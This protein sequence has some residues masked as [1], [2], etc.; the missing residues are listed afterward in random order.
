MSEVK[1]EVK[2]ENAIDRGMVT[3]GLLTEDKVRSFN[4]RV[5]ADTG[6]AMLVLPQDQVEALG[7]TEVRKAVVRY[8]DERKEER[9]V[10]GPLIVRVDGRAATVDCIVGPPN[11]EPLLGHIVMEIMDLI[12]DPLQQ[13]LTPRPESPFLP[14]LKLK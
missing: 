11:S 2:L 9:P 6:A 14:E 8:T 1:V 13:K 3:R 12:V 10:A 7:L 4:V 5:L